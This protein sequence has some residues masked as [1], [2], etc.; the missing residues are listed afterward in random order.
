[1]LFEF[2]ESAAT[3]FNID[4]YLMSHFTIVNFEL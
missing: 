1:M 4:T 3:H 2:I